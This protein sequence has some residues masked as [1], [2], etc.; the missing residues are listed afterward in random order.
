MPLL[1]DEY[2]PA[3]G[4][5]EMMAQQPL[6]VVP[7]GTLHHA[8]MPGEGSTKQALVVL[9]KFNA[10]MVKNDSKE[11]RDCFFPSQAYWKDVLALTY[12]L[13]TFTTVE[14]IVPA[15]LETKDLRG[16][17][18]EIKLVEAHL[19][20]AS[21]QFI[22]CRVN[23]RTKSPA[24]SCSGRLLLLPIKREETQEIEWKI[25]I[26]ST[27]LENLDL[28]PE[29]ES[30]LQLPS[31]DLQGLEYIETDVFIIGGGNSAAALAARLKALGVESIMA[32]RNGE[33]GDNWARRYDSMRFHVPTSF[34]E[35]PYM[36]YQKGPD[37]PHLLTRNELAE[38][39]R[40]YIDSY[41][42][43]IITSAEIQS[44]QYNQLTKQWTVQLQT[45]SGKY[46]VIC[47]HLVQATGIA[48]Q[49]PYIPELDNSNP[50]EGINIHSNE[51]QNA[52]KLREQGAKSVLVIGSANT[53][54]DV[55]RDCHLAGL[56]ATM[57]ARSRTYIVPVEYVCDKNSLGFY[58]FGV[59][60]ADRFF[61][62]LPIAVESQ[63]ARDLF[64]MFASKEPNRY[65]ALA[66]AGFPVID[67]RDPGSFLM[68][69]LVERAGGHYMDVGDTKLIAEGKANVKAG[70]EP[71]AYT[72][73]GLLFSDGSTVDADAIIWCTGFADRDARSTAAQILGGGNS[74][75]EKDLLGP[76]EIAARLDATWGIDSEGEIRGMWKR[77]LRID[78]YWIMG[79]YT[80]QHRW[81]SRTLA[82]QIKAALEGVLPP[83][84]REVPVQRA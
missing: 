55:L 11:L 78:N 41:N 20:P 30:L 44:T 47:K 67:S 83:P 56:K 3:A 18:G 84:Y 34:C 75:H 77:H 36:S 10:A 24:A 8:L 59:D 31:R 82:L 65:D 14:A 16:I 42:L 19:I 50:Y 80:Q 40:R 58:D 37:T 25:W 7:P 28:H 43:N 26:L 73:T 6:P 81:H 57:I 2:P 1:H 54:F 72:K 29:N 9:K 15:F 12:H 63:F 38:H 74:V 17:D 45:P 4:L 22:D 51:Y 52:S 71:V 70:V 32:D 79:G 46:T 69:H 49:K 35:M 48:S 76:H 66:K 61:L 39:L 13:R 68:H 60:A 27:V 33:P 62:T 23:F 53:A 21:L 64:A 5:R